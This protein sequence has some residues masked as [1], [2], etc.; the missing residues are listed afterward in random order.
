MTTIFLCGVGGSGSGGRV[1]WRGASGMKSGCDQLLD[2]G[3]QNGAIYD[4]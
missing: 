4:Q 2:N 3:D 1:E